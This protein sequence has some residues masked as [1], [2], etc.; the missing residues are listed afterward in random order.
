[1]GVVLELVGRRF[2]QRHRDGGGGVVVRAALQAGKDGLVDARGV[3]GRWHMSMAPRGPRRVL[4]VV[5]EMTSAWP[6]GDGVG[7]TGDQAGDVR[8]VGGEHGPDLAGDLGEGREV[9]R[10]GDRGAAAEDQL[11]AL[12]SAISRTS[13]MSTRPVSWRTP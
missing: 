10:A 9:D 3:L 12:G 7:A 8:D 2:L 4:W 6:T 5:V 13:S 1:M 11:G